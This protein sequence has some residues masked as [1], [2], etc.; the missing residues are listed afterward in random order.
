MT[1]AAT[2]YRQL[3]DCTQ[4]FEALLEEELALLTN[5]QAPELLSE[6]AEKKMD[7]VQNLDFLDRQRPQHNDSEPLNPDWQASLNVLARCQALNEK[8]GAHLQRQTDYN[9]RALEILGLAEP[10]VRTYAPDGLS[11]EYGGGRSIGKA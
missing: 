11:A 8:I 10:Q 1:D 5:M 3:L 2:I 4:Q 9:K 6:L 7:C